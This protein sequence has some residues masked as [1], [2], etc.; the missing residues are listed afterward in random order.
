MSFNGHTLEVVEKVRL[1]R[2]K[3]PAEDRR[4]ILTESDTNRTD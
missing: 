1:S 3:E 4:Q 2:A